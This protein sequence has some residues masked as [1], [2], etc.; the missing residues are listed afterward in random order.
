MVARKDETRSSGTPA[1]ILKPHME[2]MKKIK[3]IVVKRNTCIGAAPCVAIAPGVFQL[4]Q[5]GKAYI[6][7]PSGADQETIMMAAEACPVM[8]ILLYDEEGN[9]IYPKGVKIENEIPEEKDSMAEV[10]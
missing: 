5:E 4:D 3:K 6:V 2:S 1:G 10:S 8:A 9:R 7:D